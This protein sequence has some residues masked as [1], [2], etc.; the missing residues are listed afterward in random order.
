MVKQNMEAVLKF[1]KNN[2]HS[3]CS[4]SYLSLNLSLEQGFILKIHFFKVVAYL[5]KYLILYYQ[6]NALYAYQNMTIIE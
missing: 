5:L 2:V 1:V 4:A 6:I 3:S